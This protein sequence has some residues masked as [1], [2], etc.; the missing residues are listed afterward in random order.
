M[1]PTKL[2]VAAVFFLIAP[3]QA[4]DD[5]LLKD[6]TAPLNAVADGSGLATPDLS[7][8]F[9]R[10]NTSTAVI[11]GQRVRVGD[12]L[13]GHRVSAINAHEVHLAGETPLVLTL[14]PRVI[15]QSQ[16]EIQP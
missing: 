3:A 9:I 7:A 10:G 12:Q 11:N 15:Q 6:P 16:P 14:Y 5:K 13:G 1:R 8:I 4:A 2:A